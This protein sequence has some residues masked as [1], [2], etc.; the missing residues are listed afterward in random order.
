MMAQRPGTFL[1]YGALLLAIGLAAPLAAQEGEIPE[2]LHGLWAAGPEHCTDPASDGRVEVT[3][4]AV[5]FYAAYFTVRSVR[6]DGLYWIAE[7]DVNEEDEE[8]ARPGRL[9]MRLA[10]PDRLDIA[11]DN[12]ASQQLVRCAEGPLQR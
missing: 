5:S 4:R 3:A 8:D 12:D 1:R 10:A 2:A 11:I 6:R 7:A 9:T